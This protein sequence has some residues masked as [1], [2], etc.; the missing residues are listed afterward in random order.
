MT[1]SEEVYV[2]TL[3]LL[4]S[5]VLDGTLQEIV[6]HEHALAD[7]AFARVLAKRY[8]EQRLIVS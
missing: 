1:H 4:G 5:D 7:P 2:Q 8:T 6:D 3:N